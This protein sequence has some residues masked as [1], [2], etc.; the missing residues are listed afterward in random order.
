MHEWLF[1]GSLWG[2]SGM[3]TNKQLITALRQLQSEIRGLSLDAA[4]E[5]IDS[6]IENSPHDDF[7]PHFY[8]QKANVLWSAGKTDLAVKLLENCKQ[9]YPSEPSLSYFLGQYYFEQAMFAQAMTALDLCIASS[10]FTGDAWY[11][12]TAYLLHAYAAAK[13]GLKEIAR[14]SLDRVQD[15]EQL[16]WIDADPP[17]SKNN[18][19]RMLGR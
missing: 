16:S 10:Q 19:A 6:A 18:I 4:L 13:T 1:A 2:Q 9:K 12:D 8:V 14:R 17:V 15:E 5:K 7:R 11:L 3:S